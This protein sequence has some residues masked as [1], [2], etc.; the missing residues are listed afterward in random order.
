MD[1]EDLLKEF[2][3][4]PYM[5]TADIPPGKDTTTK[6]PYIFKSNAKSRDDIFNFI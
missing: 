1:V 6:T 2:K 3:K 4:N 5:F